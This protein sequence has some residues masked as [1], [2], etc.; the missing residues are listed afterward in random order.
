MRKKLDE[1]QKAFILL[2]RKILSIREL[3]KQ[4]PGIGE[5][6]IQKFLDKQTSV[7]N[8]KVEIPISV[9]ATPTMPTASDLL[10]N[11]TESGRKGIMIMTKA[12]SELA[13]AQP[14]TN[15]NSK[16]YD[17]IISKVK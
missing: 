15:T 1:M 12:A 5:K 11:K 17:S 2:N 8:N 4:M 13:D 7:D 6:T 14:K 9:P 3:A 16:R 10:I